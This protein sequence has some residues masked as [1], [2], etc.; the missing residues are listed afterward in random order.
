MSQLTQNKA[1]YRIDWQNESITPT[2]SNDNE[3]HPTCAILTS[4]RRLSC[5]LPSFCLS[6]S[7]AQR[8]VMRP[9]SL[10][11]VRSAARSIHGA[12]KAC[13]RADA[14]T[15]ENGSPRSYAASRDASARTIGGVSGVVTDGGGDWGHEAQCYERRRAAGQLTRPHFP[16]AGRRLA[17]APRLSAASLISSCACHAP[18]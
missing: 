13:V 6:H 4:L 10:V 11:R 9:P 14:L 1:F 3:W 7:Q 12:G 16:L 18:V 17:C 8:W 2:A 15:T 5:S